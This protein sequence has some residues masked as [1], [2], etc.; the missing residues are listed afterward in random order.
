M[1]PFTLS[2]LPSRTIEHEGDD[3]LVRTYLFFSGTSYLGIPQHPRMQAL[4]AEGVA[5][6][7]LHF[8]SSRNGNLQLAI[9]DEV[10]R[11]LGELTS[12]FALTVSSGMVAGQVVVDWLAKQLEPNAM[13]QPTEHHCTF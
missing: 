13:T 3:G 10:E 11:K 4:L 7:G 6:Y 12:G 8:G 9:Y 5:R 2:H 1:K